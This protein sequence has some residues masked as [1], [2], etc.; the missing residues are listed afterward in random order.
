MKE[1]ISP[2]QHG[3]ISGRSTSTNLAIFSNYVL[4]VLEQ[5]YQ[6]DVIYTDFSKAFDRV[7]HSIL[8]AK[9]HKL[10]FRS[11]L[12]NWFDSYLT[13]RVQYV[14]IN[15]VTSNP[16]VVTSGVPQGSH[17]GPL[18]FLLFINDIPNV[19]SNSLCL[20]Y[21][22]DLKLFLRVKSIADCIKLQ[23]DLNNLVAWC[24]NNDLHLNVSK[25]HSM[26]FYRGMSPILFSY[27]INRFAL[28]NVSEKK[29]LG[30][31]FDLKLTFCNHI[32]YIISRASSMLGFISR[33]AKDF[34][35]PFTL[36]SLYF[37]Y[38][39]SILEYCSPIWNPLYAAHAIRIERIQKRFTR[40]AIRILRWNVDMPSYKTRCLLLGIQSLETRR[41]YFDVMFVSDLINYKINCPD[42][43]SLVG[44]HVPNRTLRNNRLFYVPFHR[45]NY[46]TNEPLT[47]CLRQANSLCNV[48]DFNLYMSRD[49]F[50]KRLLLSLN[51]GG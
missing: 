37:C 19:L 45:V 44:F 40:T 35:D 31:F 41:K 39:R 8:I 25:C 6:C 38:V 51:F 16:I 3:F 43:L 24:T 2:L 15:N 1:I 42:L 47:R 49:C 18:L 23:N 5:G 12:L 36:R 34:S 29:D 28:S 32:D 22:D 46:G 11:N 14:R 10:G 7:D 21:A 4:S 9:L 48:I 20:M 50:K 13:G 26:M 33:N 30:V 17:L 27:E